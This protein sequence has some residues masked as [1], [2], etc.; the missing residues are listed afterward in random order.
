MVS[1]TFITVDPPDVY[2]ET[3]DAMLASIEL[4]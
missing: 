1:A 4:H 2:R 3:F